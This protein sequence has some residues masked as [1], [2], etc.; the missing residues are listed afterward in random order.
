M[1]IMNTEA[2]RMRVPNDVF[3]GFVSAGFSTRKK[4]GPTSL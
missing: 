1:P 3:R 4:T 2:L